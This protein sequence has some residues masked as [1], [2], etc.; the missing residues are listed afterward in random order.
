MKRQDLLVV[1]RALRQALAFI[2]KLTR[3]STAIDQQVT[4]LL[5]DIPT[6]LSTKAVCTLVRRRTSDVKRT[7]KLMEAA[8]QITRNDRHLWVLVED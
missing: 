8:R 2:E 1:E 3:Q 4:D 6:G 5:S 7:I